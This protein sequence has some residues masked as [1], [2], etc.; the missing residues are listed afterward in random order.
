MKKT[1]KLLPFL[2]LAALLAAGGFLLFRKNDRSRRYDR[3]L[4]L[5]EEGEVQEAYQ[6]LSSLDDFRDASSKKADLLSQ[7]P[8][9]P[10]RNAGRGDTVRFGRWEQDNDASNGQ[11]TI[12]WTVLDRID[13]RLL[14]LSTS[15][16]DGRSYHS[17]SFAE[18]T[19]ADSELR[20]WLNDTFLTEAF[21]EAERVFIPTVSNRNADQSSVGTEGGPDTEDRVFLLSETEVKIYLNDE[22]SQ[23]TVGRA[24]ASPYAAAH[25]VETDAEGYA[26]WWLRSPGVYP[27]SAQFIDQN[28][29]LYL[30]GAYTDIDYQFGV[31][32]VIWLS[33]EE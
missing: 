5:I 32:P 11:E 23:D 17:E 24:I 2:L 9:L 16:L 3:A 27:Y 1:L 28:G 25:Q 30:S 12:E 20:S 19:W 8:M 7:D 14:L 18:I 4:A 31:R 22:M 29:K 21:T 15:V 13:G 33:A 26:C 10:F 6:I